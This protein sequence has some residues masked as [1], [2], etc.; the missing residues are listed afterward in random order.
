LTGKYLPEKV[1]EKP[2]ASMAEKY[3]V[4]LTKEERQ[5][6]LSLIEKGKK[7][8]LGRINAMHCKLL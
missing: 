8:P 7:L 5:Q 6:L 2:G 3:I 1:V 4:N